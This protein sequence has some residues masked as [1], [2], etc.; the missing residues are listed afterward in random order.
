MELLVN[1]L[2]LVIE[3]WNL[4]YRGILNT[5]FV[6]FTGTILGLL[7]GLVVGAIRYICS[8]NENN[9]SCFIKILKKF[10]NFILGAYVEIIRGTPMMVQAM[11]FLKKMQP[12]LMRIFISTDSSLFSMASSMYT[13]LRQAKSFSTITPMSSDPMMAKSWHLWEL[14]S[15]PTV[16]VL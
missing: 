16:R 7:I 11:L 12:R 8:Y 6:S 14:V 4:L 10:I 2:N 1:S 3:Y 9:E 13:T 15:S 5:L